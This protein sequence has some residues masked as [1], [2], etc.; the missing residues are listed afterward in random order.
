MTNK[1]GAKKGAA[2]AGFAAFHGRRSVSDAVLEVPG[3]PGRL[4][5]LF[6]LG[7]VRSIVY[8]AAPKHS[9]RTRTKARVVPYVHKFRGGGPRLLGHASGVGFLVVVG[10]FSIESRGI[11]G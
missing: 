5:V 10:R 3:V 7:R 2:R 11:V 9:D 4:P 1:R 6:E 8:E